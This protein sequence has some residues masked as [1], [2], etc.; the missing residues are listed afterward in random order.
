MIKN[1]IQA[2]KLL[3]FLVGFYA[4]GNILFFDFN[5][6]KSSGWSPTDK[7]EFIESCVD[8]A[9]GSM[10]IPEATKYCN[11]VL[12]NLVADYD[13]PEDALDVDVF[14]YAIDCL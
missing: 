7:S 13:T 11:C 6:S 2:G 12:D 4:I 9:V 1:E 14:L 8:G 5:S 3:V 10:S